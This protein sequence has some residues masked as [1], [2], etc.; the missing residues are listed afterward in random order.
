VIDPTLSLPPFLTSILRQVAED[1]A[2]FSPARLEHVMREAA[3]REGASLDPDHLALALSNL[4]RI[5]LA[6]TIRGE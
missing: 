5:G 2:S 4:S 1:P 3:M 6:D